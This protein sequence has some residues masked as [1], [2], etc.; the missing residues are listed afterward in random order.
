MRLIENSFAHFRSSLAN[1]KIW[2]TGVTWQYFCET[3]NDLILDNKNKLASAEDTRLDVYFVH[4]NDLLPYDF[5]ISEYNQFLSVERDSTVTADQKETLKEM[6]ENL[7]HNRKFVEKVIKYLWDDAFKFNAQ[8]L[9]D[10]HFNS[11]ESVI[12]NFIFS[13]RPEF[14]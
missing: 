7:K 14:S 9:S 1:V 8:D 5:D 13:N 12:G 2:D 10:N 11:L 3:V 6:R 4:E